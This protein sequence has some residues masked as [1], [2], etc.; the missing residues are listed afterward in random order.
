MNN[1]LDLINGLLQKHRKNFD[2]ELMDLKNDFQS[3]IELS[4]SFEVLIVEKQKMIS[5]KEKKLMN[6][7]NLLHEKRFKILPKIKKEIET[8]LKKLDMTFIEIKM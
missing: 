8:I 3:R 1:R 5:I 2:H 4:E 6:S 7:A